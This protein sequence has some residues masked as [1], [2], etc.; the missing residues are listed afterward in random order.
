MLEEILKAI[1]I[2]FW[3]MLKFVFGPAGGYAEGFGAALDRGATKVWTVD[4]DVVADPGCLE[5]LLE[6]PRIQNMAD[7]AQ[8]Q[9]RADW[10]GIVD[11]LLLMHETSFTTLPVTRLLAEGDVLA[12]LRARGYEVEEP[13]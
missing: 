11:W 6:K 5:A 4:D 9:F 2:Y 1:T 10:S 13:L 3:C 12:Q 7:E 8:A